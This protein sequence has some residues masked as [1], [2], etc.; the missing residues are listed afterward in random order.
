MTVRVLS[1]SLTGFAR[2]THS[3]LRYHNLSLLFLTP[4]FI[5]IFSIPILGERV[6]IHRGFSV[7]IGFIGVLIVLQPGMN[8]FTS[9]TCAVLLRLFQ[10]Q[11]TH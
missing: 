6:G 3:V 1:A 5:T 11:L 7:M 9:G 10:P 2:S 8:A 4:I